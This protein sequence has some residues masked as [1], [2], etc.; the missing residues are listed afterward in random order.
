M[1]AMSTARSRSLTSRG[2][3]AAVLAALCAAATAAQ[4]VKLND[5]LDGP[6]QGSVLDMVLS[7]GGTRV[8]FEADLS[9]ADQPA[10]LHSVPLDG[11]AAPVLLTGSLA[12]SVLEFVTGGT[13]HVFVR[14]GGVADGGLYRIPAAGGDPLLLNGPENVQEFALDPTNS[15]VVY[16]A[17]LVPN[18]RELFSVPA[19]G[20]SAPVKLNGTLPAGG[21][22]WSLPAGNIRISPD[23]TRVVY[24]AD[25]HELTVIDLYSVPIDGS[26]PAI[27]LNLSRPLADVSHFR[28]SFD[29]LGVVHQANQDSF[30][31]EELYAVRINGSQPPV[32]LSGAADHVSSFELATDS[33]RVIWRNFRP[34]ES[35][36]LYSV[37]A[38]VGGTPVRLNP[39]LAPSERVM[40]ARVSANGGRVVYLLDHGGPAD[41]FS[42]PA[43]G[44]APAVQLTGPQHHLTTL[45]PY[46]IAEG[47]GR[48]LFQSDIDP[49]SSS[50]RY[51]LYSVPLDG[52]A[53]AVR[54]HGALPPGR[55]ARRVDGVLPDATVLFTAFLESNTEEGIYR[56]PIDGSASPVRI[57]D[58]LVENAS[59]QSVA[60]TAGANRLAFLRRRAT[61][62]S[63][64]ELFSCL[65]S[66]G[67]TVKLSPELGP[68]VPN[69]D[70]Q[71]D[72]RV[73]ADGSRVVYLAAEYP[74][75]LQRLHSAWT[76]GTGHSIPIEPP[77]PG[78]FSTSHSYLLSPDGAWI[79]AR[80]QGSAE[81][82][83][84]SSPVD[85]SA[86]SVRLDGAPVP[87][88]LTVSVYGVTPDSTHVVFASTGSSSSL[89]IV[90]IDGSLTP[91][92]LDDGG[93]WNLAFGPDGTRVV[94][95]K[96]VAPQRGI[97][98]LLLDGSQ[99]PTLLG[100]Q[101]S[102]HTI[103]VS[104]DSSRVVYGLTNG[105]ATELYG[106]PI[107]GSV[108]PV[109]LNA[110]SH[111]SVFDYRLSTDGAR[112]VYRA[113]PGTGPRQLYSVP[114]A[115]G[116]PPTQLNGL[117]MGSRQVT[118]FGIDSSSGRV[119]YTADERTIG[120]FEVYSVP[121]SG[122][123]PPVRLSGPLDPGSDATSLSLF[124]SGRAVYSSYT[125]DAWRIHS[126]P[127]DGS[128]PSIALTP[129]LT[130]SSSDRDAVL[131][132]D[133]SDVVYL[134]RQTAGASLQ[135]FLVPIDGSAP[136]RVIGGPLVPGGNVDRFVT[137]P[138]GLHV[139]YRADQDWDEVFEL[140]SCW[141]DRPLRRRA[142]L[143]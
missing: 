123:V 77:P 66:G 17:E 84:Y 27:R 23:G 110:P 18:V 11:S 28:I 143:R 67:Q 24:M 46:Q 115:G 134:A 124:G 50:L 108:A 35:V 116:H 9:G 113:V 2:A 41:L 93:A 3:L 97:Y 126:A 119:V 16:V 14:V 52:S 105:S 53:P 26:A 71:S 130:A 40:R 128:A 133:G 99:G 60:L 31:F 22:V 132:H 29:S 121:E 141:L 72:F 138:D 57:N 65:V 19:D 120:V 117:M 68:G 89:Y 87:D 118:A 102:G 4:S 94:Y 107:D 142:T 7:T 86:P 55:S 135:L 75:V 98:S 114:V 21:N 92:W 33:D 36:Q 73:T 54:L 129:L 101:G 8:V 42:V 122:G 39:P 139:I 131:T 43:D 79:V 127:I 20:S 103:L 100:L 95:A 12:G 140:F 137:S 56:A 74:S 25:Q 91:R 34:G 81:T 59:V 125:N 83:L 6:S 51:E 49:S 64:T 85:A 37:R 10:E 80:F 70:V 47:T 13:E 44:S 96:G 63:H 76:D 5:R 111:G 1:S 45:T 112:V 90:P 61:F 15:R 82:Y 109:Q 38:M 78:G 48:A 69:V 136:P 62:P 32:K 58:A 106:V 88:A 30:G 104:P